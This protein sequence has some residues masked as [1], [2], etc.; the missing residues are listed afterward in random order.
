MTNSESV[1]SNSTNSI[2]L[3]CNGD[4]QYLHYLIVAKKGVKS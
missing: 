2:T 3:G 1:V 4:V